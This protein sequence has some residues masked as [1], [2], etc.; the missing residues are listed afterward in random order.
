MNHDGVFDNRMMYFSTE[1]LWFP[2]R[3]HGGPYWLNPEG[4]ERH[5]P[6]NYVDNWITPMLVVQGELDY[7]VPVTQSL[8]TFTALQRKGI[9]S[10]LLYFPDENHWVLK[11][12]NSV[13]W[14]ETVT[15]WLDRWLRSDTEP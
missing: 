9:E 3:E 15:E 11:P 12:A 6:V 14:H 5:N 10:R 2:E 4:H 13:F 7:R 8:A 1:E